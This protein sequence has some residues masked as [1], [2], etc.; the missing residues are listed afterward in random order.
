[1]VSNAEAAT[2]LERIRVRLDELTGKDFPALACLLD[3]LAGHPGMAGDNTLAG[4]VYVI[5]AFNIK[6]R[7]AFEVLA[8]PEVRI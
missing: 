5:Q 4:A 8:T 1:M 3:L 7:N 2:A 6:L